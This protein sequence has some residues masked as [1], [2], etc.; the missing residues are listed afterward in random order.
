[1]FESSEKRSKNALISAT[2]ATSINI[3]SAIV[4]RCLIHSLGLSVSYTLSDFISHLHLDCVL[5]IIIFLAL[6]CLIFTIILPITL[7]LSLKNS[8]N[9]SRISFSEKI[10][11]ICNDVKENRQTYLISLLFSFINIGIF[12]VVCKLSILIPI[13]IIVLIYFLLKN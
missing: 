11:L 8:S 5:L 6:C 1:M 4:Y 3:L 9:Y 10:N 12:L 7:I 2:I 13:A